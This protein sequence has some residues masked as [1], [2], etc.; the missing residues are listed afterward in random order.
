MFPTQI[1]GGDVGELIAT[2]S[3]KT[4]H[5][6]KIGISLLTDAAGPTCTASVQSIAKKLGVNASATAS[7]GEVET[8]LDSQVSTLRN[9][10]VDSVLFCNDPVNTIKFIQAAQ[11][12][13]WHPTFVGGFVAADDVPLAAGSYASG[14]YGFTAYDF[15]DATTPGIQQYRQITQYYYPN[16]FHHFYEQ[17]AYIGAEAIVAALRKVGADLTRT[18]FVAALRSMTDFDTGMG[19]HLNFSSLGSSV[20]SGLML[21]ADSSL[22]WHVVTGRFAPA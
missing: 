16:T 13:G 8:A 3:I 1:P 9:A 21:R 6:K 18:A 10:G 4:L 12:A 7:N 5:V 17:A 11:R 20:P 22:A 2:Y 15:Y 14:M 19:L